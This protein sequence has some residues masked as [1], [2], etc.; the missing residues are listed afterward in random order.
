MRVMVGT[1]CGDEIKAD[2]AYCIAHLM[3]GPHAIHWR[4]MKGLKPYTQNALIAAAQRE[5]FSAILLVDSD[6]VFPPDTLLRLLAHD[7]PLAGCTYRARQ[8]PHQLVHGER[9]IPS[10]LMLIRREVIDTVGYP[11]ME[12]MPGQRP[13]DLVMHDVYFC[14]KAADIGF[15]PFLDE[16]LSREV[17]HLA[18]VALGHA[19]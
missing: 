11:W 15:P 12:D 4:P 6:M 14:L 3:R 16:E 17:G 19:G 8:A 1:P 9:H 5:D 10:G 18:T 2:T 13:E 7:K